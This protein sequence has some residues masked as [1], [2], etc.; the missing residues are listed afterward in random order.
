[1]KNT[2]EYAETYVICYVWKW[3]CDL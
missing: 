1:M 2:I 3:S